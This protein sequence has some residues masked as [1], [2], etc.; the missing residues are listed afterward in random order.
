M[1]TVT[2]TPAEMAA[3]AAF[4]IAAVRETPWPPSREAQ[5]AI[6]WAYGSAAKALAVFGAVLN[7]DMDPHEV[8]P[9]DLMAG[10]P[11]ERAL[12][13]AADAA[14]EAAKTARNRLAEWQR[15]EGS[16]RS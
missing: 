5:W 4:I 15:H 13:W 1:S 7:G 12:E 16:V 8:P 11:E 6:G 3:E 2:R 14:L 10:D 9:P